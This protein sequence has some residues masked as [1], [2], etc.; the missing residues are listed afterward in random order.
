MDLEGFT[1]QRILKGCKKE[2]II[3]ELSEA[4]KEFKV[5]DLK[6]RE[7]F[8]KAVHDEVRTTLTNDIK[9][10][11]L[12]TLITYPRANVKMGEFGVG[13]RGVGDFFVHRKLAEII[14]E[15]GAVVD[16]REQDD[17]GVV[18][19]S[20]GGGG[21][22]TLAVD[23]MHSRLSEFPFLAGFHAAR[24]TLRDVYV[25][26]SRPIALLSDLHLADD[27]DVGKL[28]DFT[29]G[30]ATAGEMA[31]APLVSG[32]TLRIGG[33]M[34]F[35]DRLVGAVG[36]VGSS[37]DKPK[38][39]RRAEAG[40]VILATEGSGGGTITTIALYNGYFEVVKE[41]LNMEFM[42]ACEELLK[43]K[44]L[45]RA[46][47]LSDVTNGGLRGDAT[48]I[49]RTANKK[50][51]F[52]EGELEKTVNPKVLKML[53]EL[54]IDPLGIS[55]D[56]LLLILPDEEVREVKAALEGISNVYE[57]GRVEEG[58]GVKLLAEGK[59]KNLEP[60]FREAAYTKVKKVVGEAA[61]KDIKVMQESIEEAKR[62]AM[63]KKE[64]T[65]RL[66]RGR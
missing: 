58:V 28:F 64:E 60:R 48:E 39:R 46:H 33:D 45:L 2:E 16:S 24:A 5:W 14:G 63:E 50:L 4:L 9:D 43:K 51:V 55:T 47:A 54:E 31:N 49:S 22:I 65:L 41:T 3:K 42:L 61:P 11:F 26:G 37:R 35:G 62:K 30:V 25:M 32:S 12:K 53:R 56:S 7:E 21:Y 59:E 20:D 18:R 17:A 13:S 1:R 29:A 19:E 6:K 66:L 10:S 44:L 38:A 27:G 36:A 52:Y 34:V 57:I 40:D 15:T 23:G 8:S